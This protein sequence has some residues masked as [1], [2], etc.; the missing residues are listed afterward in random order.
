MENKF[1]KYINEFPFTFN[2]AV[3]AAYIIILCL[4][5][6]AAG[7]A[8]LALSAIPVAITSVSS[9]I[10]AALL[11]AALSYPAGIFILNNFIHT[12]FSM[13]FALCYFSTNLTIGLVC[14]I[15]GGR[16]RRIKLDCGRR[17]FET[18]SAVMGFAEQ[19]HN[20]AAKK[21]KHIS[22]FTELLK[23]EEFDMHR[24]I[25]IN[26]IQENSDSLFSLMTT[27][28]LI[29]SPE[30]KNAIVRHSDFLL[31]DAVKSAI[32]FVKLIL[33]T[34][35]KNDIIEIAFEQ[36]NGDQ[37]VTADA[38]K[39]KGA[40][41]YLMLTF[42]QKFNSKKIEATINVQMINNDSCASVAFTFAGNA[43]N[44]P[45]TK[46][47]EYIKAGKE[48]K[49]VPA[50]ED[51]YLAAV[52]KNLEF[53][54]GKD[55]ELHIFEKSPLYKFN[56]AFKCRD[57]KLDSR[58][59]TFFSDG[60][61]INGRHSKLMENK[62]DNFDKSQRMQYEKKSF[63]REKYLKNVLNQKEL[64]FE[65]MQIFFNDLSIYIKELSSAIKA[66]DFQALRRT[67]HRLKGSALNVSAEKLSDMFLLLEK[68][69]Q[70]NTADKLDETFEI[71]IAE[72]EFFKTEIASS[73]IFGKTDLER[74]DHL[75]MNS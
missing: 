1:E 11:S 21:L 51:H 9:G 62:S 37:V 54:G 67:A 44:R 47:H 71:I 31:S 74:F 24:Q 64:A 20:E 70:E 42:I 16:Y 18:C 57:K 33:H 53:I 69:G 49:K 68:K 34:L 43:S 55:F 8:L 36:R 58:A 26:K 6:S 13:N 66:K 45:G 72:I 12:T 61:N 40:I 4:F 46:I 32:D 59:K 38:G 29:S 30:Q 22:C 19:F 10:A 39:L 73:E 50:A 75:Y 15:A 14:A 5:S 60:K 52:Q 35:N 7:E 27:R 63:N 2:S 25:A 28:L 17:T 48:F 3:W 23:Y 65:I 56:V 41:A